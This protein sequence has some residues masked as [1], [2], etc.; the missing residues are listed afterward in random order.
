MEIGIKR[1]KITK[2]SFM[3]IPVECGSISFRKVGGSNIYKENK[4]LTP[5]QR[6]AMN[7][8]DKIVKNAF[9]K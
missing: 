2:K 7:E 4:D 8:F 1:V 6:Q 5:L 9:I 3:F